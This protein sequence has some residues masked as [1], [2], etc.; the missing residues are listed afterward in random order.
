MQRSTVAIVDDAIDLVADLNAQDDDGLGWSL[1][2][3]A[4]RPKR[5]RAGAVVVAG[6]AAAR[7]VVRVTAV[8]ED[9]QVHF[10]LLSNTTAVDARGD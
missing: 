10:E 7:S 5:I 2:T 4:I 9:G 1:I 6:N 3:S 8:D